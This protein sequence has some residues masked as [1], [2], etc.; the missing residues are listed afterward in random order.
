MVRRDAGVEV[1]VVG[2][3]VEA[4]GETRSW[5]VFVW[6]PKTLGH[7][8]CCTDMTPVTDA[9]APK[10]R[11]SSALLLSHGLANTDIEMVLCRDSEN[12]DIILAGML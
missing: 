6:V 2:Q 7:R 1:M 10:A 8:H 11:Q 5:T 4:M 3:G 12:V 9:A